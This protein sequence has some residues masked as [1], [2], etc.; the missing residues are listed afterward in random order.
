VIAPVSITLPKNSGV[1]EAK[2][3]ATVPKNLE[4]SA[5]FDKGENRVV[6]NFTLLNPGDSINIGMLTQS[7]ELVFD[8]EARIAG[9][10]E[11]AVQ[12]A[13]PSAPV[14]S[15]SWTVYVAGAFTIFMALGTI[16]LLSMA[17]DE[18]RF[19]KLL[20]AG[21]FS[22][23]ELGSRDDVKRYIDRRFGFTTKKER[24]SLRLWLDEL[25]DSESFSTTHGDALKGRIED[26]V[27]SSMSNIGVTTATFILAV[28]GMV[29]VFMNIS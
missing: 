10:S 21:S 15:T 2:I 16:S 5:R 29:Y 9:I 12:R 25:S 17:V 19:K 24:Q 27:N 28:G 22:L 26:L 18:I 4:A 1:I 8:A 7:T 20:K 14:K 6:V 23:P 11:L 3:A 13:I